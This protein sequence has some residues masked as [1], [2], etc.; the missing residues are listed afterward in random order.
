MVEYQDYDS[1]L[2]QM[3][4]LREKG[5]F[6]QDDSVY[7]NYEWFPRGMSPNGQVIVTDQPAQRYYN[8]NHIPVTPVFQW[9]GPVGYDGK[10]FVAREGKLYRIEFQ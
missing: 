8:E 1:W 9:V 10:G 4:A 2:P 7:G 3:E 6:L 5:L